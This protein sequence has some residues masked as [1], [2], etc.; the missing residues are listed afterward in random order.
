MLAGLVREQAVLCI[1]TAITIGTAS[2]IAT[3]AVA[4]EAVQATA[5]AWHCKGVGLKAGQGFC[6][7]ML[8]AQQ[9]VMRMAGCQGRAPWEELG[10]R[11]LVEPGLQLRG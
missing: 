10:S 7:Q 6:L 1:M 4:P 2:V 5:Q 3:A 9:A 8:R 11:K